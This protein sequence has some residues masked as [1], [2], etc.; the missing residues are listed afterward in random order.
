V[1]ECRITDAINDARLR[2]PPAQRQT[3]HSSDFQCAAIQSTNT[4]SQMQTATQLTTRSIAS[5]HMMHR[6]A[7][8]TRPQPMNILPQ[9]MKRLFHLKD[10]ADDFC[11]HLI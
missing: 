2:S 3:R 11:F 4:A 8:D 6:S 7:F 9:S 1:I 10:F 5:A